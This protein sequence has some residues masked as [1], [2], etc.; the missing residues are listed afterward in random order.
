MERNLQDKEHY[1][2]RY[3]RITVESCRRSEEFFLQ[4]NKTPSGVLGVAWEIEKV[5][6]TLDWYNKKETAIEQWMR[7]DANRDDMLEK[8]IP[9]K[10]V[11]CNTCHEQMYEGSRTTWERNGNDEVLFFMR[12]SAHHLPMKGVFEDGVQLKTEAKKC[13]NCH[14]AIESKRLPSDSTVIKTLYWCVTCD[15]EENDEFSLSESKVSDDPDYNNV[16][17][18]FCLS[19]QALKDAQESYWN[20]ERMKKLVDGWKHENEHKEQY[21]KIEKLQKLTIPQV[22]QLI[23]DALEK[24]QYQNLSFEKPTMNKYVSLEF[25]LEESETDNQYASTQ[26]LKKIII[27]SLSGTNWRLMSQGIIYRLGLMSGT[28]RAYETKEDLLKLVK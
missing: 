21:E 17:A 24:Y 4:G 14:H 19:G 1:E 25:S 5:L 6:L 13:P 23:V 7:D 2:D 26:K 20:M 16:R 28:L 12:C 8:A 11:I 22:K 18:R 10:N 3:D 27:K 9:P 15:Y